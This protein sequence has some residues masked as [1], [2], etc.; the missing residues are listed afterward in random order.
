M[1]FRNQKH[2]SDIAFED[3]EGEETGEVCP[4]IEQA[5]DK[6]VCRGAKILKEEERDCPSARDCRDE[7]PGDRSF[8]RHAFGYRPV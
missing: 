4:R 2:E 7:A 3:L 8:I 6:L 1:K 5:A